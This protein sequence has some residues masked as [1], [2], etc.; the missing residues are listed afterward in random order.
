[1]FHKT[2]EVKMSGALNMTLDEIVKRGKTA[3][4]GGRGISRGR[5]RGRGGGGRGAGPARRGPLA[6]NARPSSFT[7]NKASSK[8]G[9]FYVYDLEI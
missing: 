6:V 5:G 9:I 2:I 1:M 4:S 3:R 8:S 7:I